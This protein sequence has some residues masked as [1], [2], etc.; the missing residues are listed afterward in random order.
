MKA[1]QFFR[2]RCLKEELPS[3]S[4]P[5]VVVITGAR[6]TGKTTLVR[7]CYADLEY[8]N[9]DAPENRYVLQ[10]VSS[11]AWPESVGNAVIDEAQK[12]PEI[13]EKVKYVFDEKKI[14]FTC[15]TGS[16]QIL[17]LKKL[18]ESLAGRAFFYELWPLMQSEVYYSPNDQPKQKPIIHQ[19]LSDEPLENIFADIPPVL[20]EKHDLRLR[21]AESHI[22]QWGGMPALLPL[23]DTERW[24]WLKNYGYTYL[25]RD[26]GDLARLDDLS[27]FHAFQRLS[28]LRS[29]N[30]LNFS[31]LARDAGISVD[32][33]K[34]Y[35]EYLKLSY[36]TFFLQ[37]Y[38]RN[39][40][41]QVIKTPKLFW[42]DI[43]I[44]RQL[45]GNKTGISGEIYENMVISEIYKLLKTFQFD[46]GLY[47][48]RTRSGMELD[49]IIET[50][51]GIVGIEIKA[52]E[53]IYPKDLKV[54]KK[55]ASNLGNSWKGGLVV[56]LGR[57]IQKLDQNIW[58]IPS[59]RL[60][61]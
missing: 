44:L 49:G 56:Y 30:L 55:I 1:N 2:C 36:Q 45:T 53:K 10:Q 11:A 22:L 25:E 9:L 7:D 5:R 8:I 21:E 26:L 43:G 31:E 29:S 19:I 41:S 61:Q 40:T 50:S 35:F 28:A 59:R 52:R 46:A 60:F 6:Q 15:L 39:I 20:L 12:L 42:L 27:P 13:F 54:M 37:P 51:S 32:T 58:C 14:T 57:E 23:T 38:Y 34:R 17:L 33:S 18:R 47:F 16:S 24:T 3:S 4:K 48:Y